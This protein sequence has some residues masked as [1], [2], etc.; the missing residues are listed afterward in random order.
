MP[1]SRQTL[2]LRL[3]G[4]FLIVFLCA[5]VVLSQDEDEPPPPPAPVQ[6]RSGGSGDGSIREKETRGSIVRGRAFYEDTGKPVRRG[7]IGFIKIRELVVKEDEETGAILSSGGSY[8]AEKYVLTNDQGEFVLKGVKAGV[9]ISTLKVKGVLNPEVYDRQNPLFPHISI[10]GTNE[11]QVNV[12]VKRGGAVSGKIYYPDGEPVIGA[13]VQ[14]LKKQEKVN[15]NSS[16]YAASDSI[17]VA[18][19]DDR[20]FYRFAGLPA[21]EYYVRVIEP[22]VHSETDKS[23]SSYETAQFDS[24]SELKT[25]YPSVSNIKEAKTV[26]VILGQEQGDVD[27]Q[28]PDRRLFRISGTVVAKNNKNPLNGMKVAFEKIVE[29]QRGT[30]VSFDRS[31]QT[32]T[33]E[34]GIWAFKDLPKGKYRVTVTME[35]SYRDYYSPSPQATPP[36]TDSP[37]KY[38]PLTKEIEIED[39]DLQDLVF[40]LAPEATISG[41]IVIDG[42]K[43]FPRYVGIFVFDRQKNLNGSTFISNS[44]EG[45][46]AQN[47]P[48]APKT[49]RIGKLSE[50]K[51]IFNAASEPGYYIK[52]VKLG[53]TDLLKSP[54]E[55][56]DGEAVADVQ[57]LL[58]TDVGILKGKIRNYKP[59]GRAFVAAIPVDAVALGING[60]QRSAGA[61]VKPNGEFEIKAAP[62][63]Y[64]VI[65]GT[66]KNRPAPE[67]G[68][69]D[70]WFRELVKD[71]PR[72]TL[73][74]GETETISLDYPDK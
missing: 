53:N 42:E 22:S 62:G 19:T 26:A 8:G 49:F 11:V 37:P 5:G 1:L 24:S 10:D 70:E 14:I 58:G 13:K 65:I 74:S 39:K 51:F 52:S 18:V 56:K 2:L 7:W 12:A 9:Y 63:E 48:N 20:G 68:N 29:G 69:L 17:T 32:G 57:I 46:N 31:K 67:K 61:A 28:I 3:S 71:A 34:Q 40:E 16:S 41:T 45:K 4:L 66:D 23:V 33:N 38:A 50:G 47:K 43:P 36:K 27:I 44:G 15:E 6:L 64:F 59:E 72:V 25:F 54:L 55:L 21:Y 73:K 30:Y 60:M 35:D